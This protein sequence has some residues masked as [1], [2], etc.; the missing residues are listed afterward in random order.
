MPIE[1]EIDRESFVLLDTHASKSDVWKRTGK[2]DLE[3]YQTCSIQL[4]RVPVYP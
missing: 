3:V 1:H 4:Q 2:L